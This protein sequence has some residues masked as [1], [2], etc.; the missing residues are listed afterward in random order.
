MRRDVDLLRRMA[1]APPN[2][3]VG[4]RVDVTDEAERPQERRDEDDRARGD[5]EDRDDARD[6][7][8]EGDERNRAFISAFFL[9]DDERAEKDEAADER[10]DGKQNE[11]EI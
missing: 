1:H 2:E 5:R 3:P 4:Q 7:R 8:A 6:Q 9:G 10:A 11:S